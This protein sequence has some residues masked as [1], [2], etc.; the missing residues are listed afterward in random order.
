MFV[1]TQTS[2]NMIF[3]KTCSTNNV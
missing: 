2:F 3:D 1:Q